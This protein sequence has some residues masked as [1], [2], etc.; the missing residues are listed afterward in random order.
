MTKVIAIK[1]GQFG[2]EGKGSIVGK[3]IDFAIDKI[4]DYLSTPNHIKHKPILVMRYQGGANAGH[5]LMVNGKTYKFH[6]TPSGIIFPYTYNLIGKGVLLNP[7][8]AMREIDALRQNR[9]SVTKE[10][11]GIAG[12]THITLDFHIKKDQP[13]FNKPVHTSTG[14]GIKQTAMDKY[15][16]IGIRFADFLDKAL[17]RATLE[18]NMDEKNLPPPFTNSEDIYAFV[19]SYSKEIEVLGDFLTQEHEA[20]KNHGTHYKLWES[21]QGVGLDIDDG[22]Y[23]GTTS[24]SPSKSPYRTDLVLG[25]FKLYVSSVGR[26]ERAFVTRIDDRNLEKHLINAWDERGTTTGKERDLGWFDA[27]LANYA[28]S[29]AEID[30]LVGT[31]GDRLE[32]LS[33]LEIKPKIA[34]AYEINGKTYPEWDPLFFRRDSLYKA[35]PVYEEFE[36]WKRFVDDNGELT[37]NA[38]RYIDRIQELTGKEF[39]LLNTGPKQGDYIMLEDIV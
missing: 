2:D 35:R 39:I 5:T 33:E 6:Q 8:E 10:N 21:A 3:V 32:T 16:R 37:P 12:N 30:Y 36:P 24:S 7:R 15:G 18:K 25:V 9:T 34:V 38:Q 27:V 31:C 19:E 1:G 29:V 22:L 20:L 13:D 26:G 4:G 14:R 28:I 23:P 17:F 11:F